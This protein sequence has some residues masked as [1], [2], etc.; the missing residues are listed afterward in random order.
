MTRRTWAI[1]PVPHFVGTPGQVVEG[2]VRLQAAGC[3][4]VQIN[5][6]DDLADL[7]YFGEAVIPMRKQAGL[8]T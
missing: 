3:A 4:G 8:R 5:V 1:R 2:P 7:A 6:F